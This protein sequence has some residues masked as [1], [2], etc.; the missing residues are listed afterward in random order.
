MWKRLLAFSFVLTLVIL[1]DPTLTPAQPGG[2]GKRGGNGGGFSGAPGGG[3]GGFG[4][5]NRGGP[6]GFQRPEGGPGGP[7]SFGPPGG[8]GPGFGGGPPGGARGPGGGGFGSRGSDPERGWQRLLQI[9]QSGGDTVDLSKIPSQMRPWL[10]MA[11]QYGGQPLPESGTWTKNDYLAHHARNEEARAA[12]AARG[13]SG[14]SPGDPNN[15]GRDRSAWGQGN[16][17][18]GGW[19]QGG[20][21]QGGG[22][23]QNG[24]GWGQ[25]PPFEKKETE[26]E[27][28]VAM[29]YGKLPKGLPD[30][31]NEDDTDKDGQVSLYEWRKAGKD[32]KEFLAMDLN[33]D[34]LVTADE[35]LR[36][37]RQ[38]TI[39]TKVAAYEA[40][41][42]DP[43]NW[44]I[45]EKLDAATA[46]ATPAAR[47]SAARAA[48][49]RVAS[50]AGGTRAATTRTATPGAAA[51]GA[52]GAATPA[53]AARA[54]RAADR[55]GDSRAARRRKPAG[56]F[57]WATGKLTP[58]RYAVRAVS[59]FLWSR[60][61]AAVKL[62]RPRPV[63]RGGERT[64][65]P[66]RAPVTWRSRRGLPCRA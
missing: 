56:R 29:R 59:V 35:Y 61:E 4:G 51:G 5:F 22:W 55:S 43:G 26:E 54:R 53:A 63:L 24:G 16:G 37:S 25:R 47:A 12:F 32:V 13:N 34:N 14:G 8:G 28:P 1:L 40:G 39:D 58:A 46:R 3:P 66:P 62:P 27:R 33:G 45:G 2:K 21:G 10:N 41:E 60:P 49:A 19:G 9:T 52:P 11:T 42:R 38:K 48:S 31:Y 44:G 20:W 64:L 50:A 17:G 23:D 57:V 7:G 30:W 36:F 18:P 15:F 65:P 6:G